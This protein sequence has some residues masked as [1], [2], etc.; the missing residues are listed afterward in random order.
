MK[1]D[2]NI[3]LGKLIA[4]ARDNLMLDA[5]DETYTLNR[6]GAL[7]GATDLGGVKDC[8]YGDATLGALLNELEAAA[9]ALDRAAVTDALFPLPHTV[10][11]YFSDT[12][13]R[14]PKKA[15][16]FLFD[17]YAFGGFAADGEAYSADGFTRYADGKAENGRAVVIDANGELHYVPLNRGNNIAV[18]D[19]DDFMSDDIARRMAA[20]VT[21]YGG[22]IATR[23]GGDGKYYACD[24]IAPAAAKAKT[25]LADGAVKISLLDY[26]VPAISVGGL[27]KNTVA[28]AAAKIIKAATDE[29]L[30]CVAACAAK[31]E[32][33]EFYVIFANPVGASEYISAGDALAACGVFGTVDFSEFTQIL[34]KG[35]AL[36]ADLSA[37][38]PLYNEIGGVKLGA[39]ASDKL[40]EALAAVFKKSLAA[41]ASADEAKATALVG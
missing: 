21:N 12:L 13:G 34:E 27:A 8:D 24:I 41:A 25:K 22:A 9:P 4:Y 1:S 38:K 20:Y 26:P 36:P 28:A 2:I 19:C 7:A 35:T 11:Y 3:I 40:T 15:F 10:N 6:I 5:L 16:D 39:K 17:L 37:F 14:S 31:D 18:I 29:K 33:A 23:I 30:A 32:G